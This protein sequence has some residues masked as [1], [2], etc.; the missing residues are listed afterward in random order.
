MNSDQLLHCYKQLWSSRSFASEQS[1]NSKEVL[2]QAIKKDLLDEMT[3]PRVRKTAH[4]KYHWAIKRILTSS[5]ETNEKLA[6][7]EQ[8]TNVYEELA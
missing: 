3:H 5:L 4:V 1:D 7:I 8:Y 6:L 2:L